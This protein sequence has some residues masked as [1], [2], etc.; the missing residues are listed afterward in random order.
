MMLLETVDRLAVPSRPS[1]LALSHFVRD[2]AG[3]LV[4]VERRPD[5][6]PIAFEKAGPRASVAFDPSHARAAIVTC[7]GLCPG[8]NDVVRGLFMALHHA[9]RVPHVLGFR[10]GFEGMLP[11]APEPVHLTP[12]WARHIHR[13]GG[14]VL[15][16]SRGK[17]DPARVV[18]TLL[19]IGV[20]MLF[21]VGG[22]G[23]LRGVREICAELA[24]RSAPVA[25]VAVPKTIDDDVP[26]IDKTFGFDTA[27]EHARAAI[28]SAHVEAMG[29]KNGV[30]VVKLMGRDA[31]FIAACATL[32]SGE[33]NFCLLPEF[34]FS[35]E[36]LYDAVRARLVS[37]GHAVVVV[38]EGCGRSLA[39]DTAERDASG[40]LRYASAELDAGA[41]LR[42]GLTAYFS[43][44]GFPASVKYIDPSYTIR[45]ACANSA[46]AIYC[47]ELARNA[48]HA[49]MAGRTNTLVGRMHG[50]YVHVPIPIAVASNRQVD[51]ALWRSVREV[52]GQPELE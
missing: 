24:R 49:A 52:T 7:G 48:V 38:A 30:G 44:Q 51:L 10:F 50:V 17:R 47:S 15:G 6:Q 46:D 32:A 13:V 37:R 12:E 19:R 14:S 2:D 36:R 21:V 28:D 42:D 5:E 45:A 29:A 4:D 31:G 23:T 16:S 39:K 33:A 26:F 43:R 9:Y 1:P 3:V 22:N 8:T 20:Q 41:R 11:D 35:P 27:V 34:P 40:N 25:V 18:D